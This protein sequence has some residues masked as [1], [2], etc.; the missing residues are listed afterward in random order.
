MRTSDKGMRLARWSLPL[1]VLGL[2]L[3]ACGPN[4]RMEAPNGFVRYEDK[5]NGL[6]LITPD[7][8]R[9]RSREVRNY[10][11]GDL[12]FWRDAMRRHLL[13]R[14]YLLK[15]ERCFQT[16]RGLDGCTAEFMV[17]HGAEDWVLSETVFVV[18]DKIALVEAAGPFPRFAKVEKALAEALTTFQ[19]E[20]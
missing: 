19:P 13:A 8:V 18:G 1:V 5:K 16:K 17:P 4:H 3:G 14:G 9:V 11:K 15:S 20:E 7:G 2:F 10:P 12:P 6:H